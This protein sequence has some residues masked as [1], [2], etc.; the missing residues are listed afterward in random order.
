M[1]FEIS[2]YIT[3]AEQQLTPQR[4]KHSLGVMQMMGELAAIYKLDETAA[5]TAGILHDI[6][7]EF[8]PTELIQWA[9]ENKIAL[10]SEYDRMPLFL[11]GPVGACYSTQKLELR[12][13]IILDAISRHSYFGNGSALSPSFCWC[14]RLADLLEPSRDWEEL[15]IQL[16]PVAY[17]GELGEAAYLLMQWLIPFHES[18]SLPVHPNMRRVFQELSALREEKSLSESDSLPI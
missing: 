11:H 12:D 17:A 14:L 3:L 1:N 13:A 5:L 18:A 15:K 10:R 2:D 6:A 9:G 8:P 7:K 4:F 16:K